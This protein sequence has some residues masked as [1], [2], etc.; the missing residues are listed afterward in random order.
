MAAKKTGLGR[1][2]DALFPDKT[3]TAKS[4]TKEVK[5]KTTVHQKK[6]EDSEQEKISGGP[7]MV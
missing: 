3:V 7:M 5:E 2:L 4:G 6:K 1:G